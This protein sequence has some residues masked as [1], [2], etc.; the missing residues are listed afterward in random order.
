[1][2]PHHVYY[3]LAILGLLWLCVI[4]HSLW[5]SRGV[6]SPQ[7]LAAPVP[8]LGKRKR[9]NEPTPFEGL[10]QRPY[11]AACEHDATHPKP[12]PPLRPDPMP[13]LNRRPCAIDTSMHFCPH[14][15]CA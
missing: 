12:Q 6:L 1:M 2:M 7:P 10:T 9:S 5:L 13:P 14:V 15:D 3:Q 11:C 8:P 4:L